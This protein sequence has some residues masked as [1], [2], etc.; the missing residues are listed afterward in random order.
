MNTDPP[1]KDKKART[2]AKV[3]RFQGYLTGFIFRVID[4]N[5]MRLCCLAERLTATGATCH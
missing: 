2:A 3:G 4:D 5:S 1:R